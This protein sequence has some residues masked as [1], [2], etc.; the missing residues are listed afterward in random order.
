MKNSFDKNLSTAAMEALAAFGKTAPSVVD[1]FLT[2]INKGIPATRLLAVRA[3]GK[4]AL[5]G[6]PCEYGLVIDAPVML[7]D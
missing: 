4:T 1:L 3:V 6:F 7:S 5:P 2:E